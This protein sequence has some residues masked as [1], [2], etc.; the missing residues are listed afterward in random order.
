MFGS[1][2]EAAGFLYDDPRMSVWDARLQQAMA[3]INRR[4]RQMS[5][6]A[7]SMTIKVG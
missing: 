3:L 7:A 5:Q 2:V 4:G 6:G 1:L